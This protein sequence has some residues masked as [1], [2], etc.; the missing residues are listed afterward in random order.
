MINWMPEF[1]DNYTIDVRNYEMLKYYKKHFELQS[2]KRL[3]T[4]LTTKAQKWEL[5]Y[6]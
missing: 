1:Y 5:L 3:K 2:K 4:P 6:I